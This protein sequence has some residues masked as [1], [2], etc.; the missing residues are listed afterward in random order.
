MAR[1]D[2]FEVLSRLSSSIPGV[3]VVSVWNPEVRQIEQYR[4]AVTPRATIVTEGVE[5]PTLDAIQ[6][7]L[8]SQLEQEVVP[9]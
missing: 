6:P 8:E 3:I 9:A 2:N 4:W 5:F 1:G 7:Y